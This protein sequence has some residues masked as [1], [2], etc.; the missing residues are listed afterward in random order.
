MLPFAVLYYF[1]VWQSEFFLSFLLYPAFALNGCRA[2]DPY[3]LLSVVF[4]V[5]F[6]GQFDEEIRNAAA[7]WQPHI[8]C[9][10]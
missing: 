9:Q 8:S 6:Y 5:I 10:Y 1:A 3:S 4:A 2:A 7:E